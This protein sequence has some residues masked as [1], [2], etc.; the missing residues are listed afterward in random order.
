MANKRPFTDMLADSMPKLVLAPSFVIMMVCIYGYILW[1]AALSFTKSRM[2]PQWDFVG[3]DQYTKLMA[4]DRW[5]VSSQNLIIFG[6]MFILIC[7]VIGITMAILLDQKIRQ[8]GFLRT[9]YLYPMAISF[10]VTGTAWKWLLNPSMGIQ[11]IVRDWGYTDFTFDWLVNSEMVVFCLVI[12]AVWQSSGFVMALFLAGLR[13]VDQEMIKA[14]QLDGASLP[15]VYRR[16]ILPSLK[17]VFFSAFVILSHI[18]IKS[19]DLVTALTGGGPGYSS[20]LPA[21]FMYA[22]AFTRSQMGLGAAS[23]MMMLGGVLAIL[24]P[25]LYSELRGKKQ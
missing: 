18:A 4:N 5:A 16:I 1:T 12:A 3:F 15:T 10:I 14:A 20:D 7:L 23:G 24:I 17:P 8:E 2:L 9:I 6:G 19:F 21:N 22:H 13:G 11:Q 25:Y